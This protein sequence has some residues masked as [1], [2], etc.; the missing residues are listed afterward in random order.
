[1]GG[2]PFRHLRRSVR[3]LS[4]RLVA[5]SRSAADMRRLGAELRQAECKLPIYSSFVLEVRL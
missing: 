3:S 2:G 5:I 1:M 4:A